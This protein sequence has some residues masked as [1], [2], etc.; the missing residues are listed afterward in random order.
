ML[1]FS[2]LPGDLEILEVVWNCPLAAARVEFDFADETLAGSDC[3]LAS[4]LLRET[5]R[6]T[7]GAGEEATSDPVSGR[8]GAVCFG[9]RAHLWR[10]S[11]TQAIGVQPP[12]RGNAIVNWERKI[13]QEA[14]ASDWAV[15]YG[16]PSAV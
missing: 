1:P 7:K 11:A 15:D 8:I 6:R 10:L 9:G 4:T 5:Q 3:P 12:Q 2:F 16:D 14:E 13:R